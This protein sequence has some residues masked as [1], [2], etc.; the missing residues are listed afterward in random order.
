MGDGRWVAFAAL[1]FV[2]LLGMKS[3]WRLG[4]LVVLFTAAHIAVR[5]KEQRFLLPVGAIT[6]ALLVVGAVR[7]IQPMILRH[8]I[9]LAWSGL[10]AMVAV[11]AARLPEFTW[12]WDPYHATAFLLREA[13]RQPDLKGV[14]CYGM[15]DANT[16]N[17]FFLSKNVPLLTHVYDEF[18]LMVTRP[19][20]L[21]GQV[22]Y[23]ICKAN[24]L[25]YFE[26]WRPLRVDGCND[27]ILVRLERPPPVPD[28]AAEPEG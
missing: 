26:K 10:V 22:N 4:L 15:C 28:G 5:H 25:R 3:E 17:Y 21:S 12:Q 9:M 1:G 16:A 20:W 7:Y 2:L 11:S 18:E 27:Y 23:L 8:R 6:F 19:E 14:A 13:G 24:E